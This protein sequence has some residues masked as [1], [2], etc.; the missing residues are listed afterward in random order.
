MPYKIRT[1]SNGKSRIRT[2]TNHTSKG[3]RYTHSSSIKTGGTRITSSTSSDGSTSY[4]HTY[5]DPNGYITKRKIGGSSSKRKGSKKSSD[6]V[7]LFVVFLFGF[8]VW[9]AVT[10]YEFVISSYKE[11]TK[12][13]T[14]SKVVETVIETPIHKEVVVEEKQNIDQFLDSEVLRKIEQSYS[15]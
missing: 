10:M 7:N 8:V 5:T 2:T 6:D 15:E 1:K 14:K 9:L 3:S 4:W 13:S 12:T 11:V